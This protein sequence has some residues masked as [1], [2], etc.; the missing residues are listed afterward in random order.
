[1]QLELFPP[2]DVK[3]FSRKEIRTI[4]SALARRTY[5]APSELGLYYFRPDEYIFDGK[6]ILDTN[7]LAQKIVFL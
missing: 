4:A 3:Y 5:K 7:F 2:D 1:M 6:T